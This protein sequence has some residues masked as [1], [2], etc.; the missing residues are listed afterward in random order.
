MGRVDHW[1]RPGKRTVFE[2]KVTPVIRNLRIISGSIVPFVRKRLAAN[3][4][5]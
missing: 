3:S 4:A 2:P 1:N 5:G